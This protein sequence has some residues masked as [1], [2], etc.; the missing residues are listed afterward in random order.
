MRCNADSRIKFIIISFSVR[1][2]K[3]S[4]HSIRTNEEDPF[5]WLLQTAQNS[6]LS[7]GQLRVIRSECISHSAKADLQLLLRIFVHHVYTRYFTSL[8]PQSES[9]VPVPLCKITC[10]VS[11]NPTLFEDLKTSRL[12]QGLLL[13][14]QVRAREIRFQA[15][16][17]NARLNSDLKH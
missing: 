1:K 9:P 14:S 6:I 13:P 10:L 17:C 11:Y 7:L 16:I 8:P 5:F 2:L 3:K 15:I 12:I 4:R